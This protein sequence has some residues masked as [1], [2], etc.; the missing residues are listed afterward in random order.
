M[1]FVRTF[2]VA[3]SPQ[4]EPP[5]GM[6]PGPGDRVIAADLGGAHALAWGWPVDLLVGDLDSLGRGEATIL[7]ARGVPVVTAPA[8][9]DETDLELALA[10][11]L[12][13]DPECIIICAALGGRVDHLLAN[14]FLLARPDLAGRDVQI[15]DGAEIVRLLRGP[16]T[17]TL[18]GRPGDL[19]SLLPLGDA[20]GGVVTDGLQY[21]LRDE[22]LTLGQGRGVSN[23]FTA[24][25][26]SVRLRQGMLLVV[27]A[28]SLV[29][30]GLAAITKPE[31]RLEPVALPVHE[32]G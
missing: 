24:D 13:E 14:V 25:E 30:S 16:E 3:G 28:L 31:S 5:A 8:T 12:E 7:R 17:L 10:Y 9:K 6:V 23:V 2:I 20:A 22:T 26:A 21:P 11:A 18:S 32:T 19:L 15:A 29:S 4:G 27:H 1:R